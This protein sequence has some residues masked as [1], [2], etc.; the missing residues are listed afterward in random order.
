MTL[1]PVDFTIITYKPRKK[2]LRSL[3]F[4]MNSA[5]YRFFNTPIIIDFVNLQESLKQYPYTWDII[6]SVK[7]DP[8]TYLDF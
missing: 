5:T 4:L 2:Q 6:I 7:Q 1:Y 8:K 3:C